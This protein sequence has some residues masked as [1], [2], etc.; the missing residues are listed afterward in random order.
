M[1]QEDNYDPVISFLLAKKEGEKG[2]L[3]FGGVDPDLI[4]PKQ[5]VTYLDTVDGDWYLEVLNI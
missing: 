3:T 4:D 2:K 1:K 5:A